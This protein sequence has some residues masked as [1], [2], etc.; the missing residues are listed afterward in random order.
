MELGIEPVVNLA[1]ADGRIF[2]Y[3]HPL[4]TNRSVDHYVLI[5]LGGRR[6]GLV[7]SVSRLVYFGDIPEELQRRHRAVTEVDSV[8]IS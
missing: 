2:D 4:P 1:A 7:A 6:N 5:V 3:R 8:L